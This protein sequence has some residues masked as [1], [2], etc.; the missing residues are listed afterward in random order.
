VSCTGVGEKIMVLSLAKEAVNFLRFE[1]GS[2]AQ[3]AVDHALNDLS[4]IKGDGGLICIDANGDIGYGFNTR[5]MTM[6]YID[7]GL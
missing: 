6:H 2:T 5:G 4:S 7:S 3:D 1:K